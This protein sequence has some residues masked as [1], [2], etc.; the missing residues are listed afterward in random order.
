MVKL[1]I[2]K[3]G[4]VAILLVV[5]IGFGIMLTN[6]TIYTTADLESQQIIE[7]NDNYYLLFDDRKLKL[8]ENSL[9]QLELDKFPTYK[10]TYS[11]NKLIENKGKV[12]RLE[13]YGKQV[14]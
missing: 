5:F 4:F 3:I 12:L 2:F 1:N 9:K 6:V 10:L 7:E 13:V 11:Y 8:S 14:P